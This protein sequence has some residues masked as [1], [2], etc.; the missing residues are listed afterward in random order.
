MQG[1]LNS[2]L[3]PYVKE[4]SYKA[5]FIADTIANEITA[6]QEQVTSEDVQKLANSTKRDLMTQICSTFGEALKEAQ[7]Q[8][9]SPTS[10]NLLIQL[11]VGLHDYE[12]AKGEPISP[13]ALSVQQMCKIGHHL[14]SNKNTQK[15]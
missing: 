9:F 14:L 5:G 15:T 6:S 11:G 10:A 8:S 4:I 7:I 13:S 2:L 12:G 1:H 3:R